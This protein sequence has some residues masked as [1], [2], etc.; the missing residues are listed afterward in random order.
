M[1]F[2]NRKDGGGGGGGNKLVRFAANVNAPAPNDD[3][4]DM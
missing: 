4:T 2:S 1:S 3:G